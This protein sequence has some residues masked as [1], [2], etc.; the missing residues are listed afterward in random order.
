MKMVQGSQEYRGSQCTAQW[1]SEIEMYELQRRREADEFAH[2]GGGFGKAMAPDGKMFTVGQYSPPGNFMN[3][4]RANIPAPLSGEIWV[5]TRDDINRTGSRYQLSKETTTS[6]DGGSQPARPRHRPGDDHPADSIFVE[7]F[8]RSATVSGNDAA[9]KDDA[10]L[11]ETFADEVAKQH[12][13]A[14]QEARSSGASPIEVFGIRLAQSW[15]ELLSQS[16]GLQHRP[17]RTSTTP[18][19][20]RISRRGRRRTP[21]GGTGGRLAGS[22]LLQWL[23][24]ERH[25]FDFGRPDPGD[26][27]RSQLVWLLTREDLGRRAGRDRTPGDQYAA[28]FLPACGN[29]AGQFADN[30]LPA[31][32]KNAGCFGPHS[33]RPDDGFCCADDPCRRHGEKRLSVLGY[34]D[35]PRSCPHPLKGAQAQPNRPAGRSGIEHRSDHQ[36]AED[37]GA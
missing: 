2:Q 17:A 3:K 35:R 11:R 26:N 29:L 37:R 4:W 10:E 21:A 18:A 15:A 36:H 14:A 19:L 22:W 20:G 31:T 25:R 24:R 33:P 5:P 6:Q 12:N 23:R 27:L 28:C 30:V 32:I 13:E 34:A 7:N 9:A 1:Y 8:G 16:G